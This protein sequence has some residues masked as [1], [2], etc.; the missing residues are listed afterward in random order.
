MNP[1]R[2][3]CSSQ[4]LSL[5]ASAWLVAC[6][7][8][9]AKPLAEAPIDAHELI[10]TPAPEPPHK[11]AKAEPET[12]EETLLGCWTMSVDLPVGQK[13]GKLCF[14]TEQGELSARIFIKKQWRWAHHVEVVAGHVELEFDAPVG[15]AKISADYTATE[16]K[17]SLEGNIGGQRPFEARRVTNSESPSAQR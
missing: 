5:A 3:T 14:E 4:S 17:G 16:M 2:P 13:Q 6:G 1:I 15:K 9:E 7:P 8:A 11:R 12:S 10:E